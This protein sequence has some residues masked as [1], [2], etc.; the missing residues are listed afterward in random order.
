MLSMTTNRGQLAAVSSRLR[1]DEFAS[2]A[3]APLAVCGA[4]VKIPAAVIKHDTQ[5]MWHTTAEYFGTASHS[6]PEV[7]T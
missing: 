7:A 3:N 5:G 2:A 1:T 6:Q 4:A